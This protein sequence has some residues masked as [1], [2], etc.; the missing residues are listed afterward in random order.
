VLEIDDIAGK[1]RTGFPVTLFILVSSGTE[2]SLAN[3]QLSQATDLGK[4]RK[5]SASQGRLDRNGQRNKGRVGMFEHVLRGARIKLDIPVVVIAQ[6]RI[7]RRDVIN[8]SAHEKQIGLLEKA[9][10]GFVQQ[11]EVG[12]GTRPDEDGACSILRLS[13]AKASSGEPGR[14]GTGSG[15]F[16]SSGG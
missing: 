15:Q 13:N 1:S 14:G 12:K 3:E 16:S 11:P 4:S 10:I 6:G 7:T 8:V 5:I 2:F 9:R